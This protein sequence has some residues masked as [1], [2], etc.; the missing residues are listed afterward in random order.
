M[1]IYFVVYHSNLTSANRL[2]E[3]HNFSTAFDSLS[4]IRSIIKQRKNS[5]IF[6]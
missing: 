6:Y 5:V 3:L 2:Q 4:L 1:N